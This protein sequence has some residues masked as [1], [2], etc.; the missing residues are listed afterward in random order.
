MAAYAQSKISA[1]SRMVIDQYRTTGQLTIPGADPAMDFSTNPSFA[2]KSRAGAPAVPAFIVFNDGGSAALLADMGISV[3]TDLGSMVTASIPLDRVDEIAEQTWVKQIDFCSLQTPSLDFARQSGAVSTVQSGFSYN[4]TTMSFD[5]SGVICGIMDTGLDPNHINFKDSNGQNRIERLWYFSGTDGNANV[6]EYTASTIPVGF[7]DEPDESHATHVAGIMGGSYT[8]NAYFYAVTTPDGTNK[9]NHINEAAPCP[10]YGV[11]TGAS[12]ALSV[13]SLYDAN[14]VDGVSN[15]IEYAEAEGKPVVV[16]LSLG[17]TVGP[18]DGTDGYSQALTLLGQRGIICMSAGNDGD[19]PISLTKKFTSTTT[20]KYVMTGVGRYINGSLTANHANGYYDVWGDDATPLT[21]KIGFVDNNRNTTVILDTST[22]PNSSYISSSGKTAFTSK[23]NGSITVYY[24][25]ESN[26]R[27]NVYIVMEGVSPKSGTTENIFVH[28]AGA[29]GHTAYIYGSSGV[30]MPKLTFRATIDGTTCSSSTGNSSNSINDAACAD[31]VIS[32][33]AYVSRRTWARLDGSVYWYGDPSTNGYIVGEI[34]PFSSYGKNFAGKRLPL[35][36]GP[37]ANI[38]SSYS[39][40]YLNAH[41]D[42]LDI[43]NCRVSSSSVTHYWGTMQGTSMSCPFVTGTVGLWLQADP[44]LTYSKVIEVMENT[45]TTN[46]YTEAA[47]ERWGMGQINGEAGIRYVLA[48]A[49]I[50]NVWS[51][52]DQRLV[53]EPLQGALDVFVA[54]ESSLN[55]SLIDLQGRTVGSESADAD[56]V[57]IATDGLAHGV[58]IL[59]ISG[60]DSNFTRKITL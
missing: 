37:G 19:E 42:E 31:N 40:Q 46:S 41:S 29:N 26:N 36:A 59:K 54:G 27:Y 9:I 16:N 57:V 52:P 22:N 58:Y 12:L 38:I 60:A 51:D 15:I 3:I 2:P 11:A 45:C 50:G 28:T 43:M 30:L 53:V 21:V 35:V 32:V 17:S 49:A 55:V 4:G 1:P 23:F 18:H 47:P 33:G 24:G 48:N 14:I 25:V 20:G 39:R 34:A 6:T 44:T 13:G 8:G 56:R 7:T 5:G 10:Y